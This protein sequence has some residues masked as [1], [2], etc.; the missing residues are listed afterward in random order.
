M[1]A[2]D[3]ESKGARILRSSNQFDLRC[4]CL[5]ALGWGSILLVTTLGYLASTFARSRCFLI[6]W[7]AQPRLMSVPLVSTQTELNVHIR[8]HQPALL[9]GTLRHWRAVGT[10]TPSF[11][12]QVLG[13]QPLEIY[14]WGASGSNWKRTRLFEATMAQFVRLLTAH[15]ARALQG[16]TAESTLGAPY[17]QED[18]WLLVEHEGKLLP[19]LNGLR[20]FTPQLPGAGFTR[21][22]A[23]WMGPR[24]A[25]TGIHYDS[26]NALLMQIHGTSATDARFG[27][28]YTGLQSSAATYGSLVDSLTRTARAPCVQSVSPCGRRRLDPVSTPPTSTITAPSSPKWMWPHQTSQRSRYSPRSRRSS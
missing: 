1:L 17:L 20:E 16:T 28:G 2:D 10:W 26:V 24:G 23:F 11:F 8:A 12:A 3:D 5:V 25:R 14:F 18:E 13:E 19:D 22:T 27:P 9:H 4:A 7:T 15:E 21:E 6:D